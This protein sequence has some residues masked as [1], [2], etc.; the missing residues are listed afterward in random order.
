MERELRDAIRAGAIG[1]TTSR[2]PIHETPDGRPVA[3]RL[4]T[5]DEVRR[6]VGVM[7]DLNAGLFEMAGEA[8]GGDVS[9]PVAFREYYVRLLDLA[10]GTWHSCPCSNF[11]R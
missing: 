11:S 10:D 6:L 4:A 1:F 8:V 9:D 3:S 2:S 5:W 7:G